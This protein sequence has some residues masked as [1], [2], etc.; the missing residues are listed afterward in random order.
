MRIET[1][2][3]RAVGV[4]SG[5]TTL[6]LLSSVDGIP[7]GGY[8]ENLDPPPRLITR[9]TFG[10]AALLVDGLLISAALLSNSLLRALTSKAFKISLL[11]SSRRDIVTR[12]RVKHDGT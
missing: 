3:R 7:R 5:N 2:G 8:G 12:K 9:T 6:L 1:R 10:G 11:I 4:G